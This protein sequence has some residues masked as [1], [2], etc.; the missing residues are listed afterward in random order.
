MIRKPDNNRGQ[1]EMFGGGC[2]TR[3]VRPAGARVTDP[4]TSEEAIQKL[5]ASGERAAQCERVL[6]AVQ[7][8]PGRTSRELSVFHGL[9][10]HMVARRLPELIGKVE[11][12]EIRFCSIGKIRAVTWIP[13]R[14][15]TQNTMEGTNDG[16]KKTR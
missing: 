3:L 16:T 6:R 13:A 4:F 9:D 14:L 5:N 12:G 10:R 15:V 1:L 7:Q 2:P 8:T 11:K